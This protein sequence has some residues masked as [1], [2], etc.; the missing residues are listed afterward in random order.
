MNQSGY[1]LCFKSLVG[2]GAFVFPCDATG[3]VDMDNIGE[4]SRLDY[5]Y[6]RA[7]MGIE[8]A[9]PAILC[10]AVLR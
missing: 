6:A 10:N 5:F 9:A 2:D 3:K 4:R 1:R 8:V 7:V